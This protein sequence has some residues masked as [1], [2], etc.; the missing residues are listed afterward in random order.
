MSTQS[1]GPWL[2]PSAVSIVSAPV[3]ASLVTLAGVEFGT[4]SSPCRSISLV[5]ALTMYSSAQRSGVAPRT[6]SC[7]ALPS[8]EKMPAISTAM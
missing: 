7:A 8:A 1:N 5:S 3:L 6:K 2:L 4:S